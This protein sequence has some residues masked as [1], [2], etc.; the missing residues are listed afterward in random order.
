MGLRDVHGVVAESHLCT[1]N[2]LV[3]ERVV[4][5]TEL[6]V[7]NSSENKVWC[8]VP[9]VVRFGEGREVSQRSED[10]IAVK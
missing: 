7:S 4:S 2:L 5:T 6:R 3:K 10:E 9:L 1:V 8:A